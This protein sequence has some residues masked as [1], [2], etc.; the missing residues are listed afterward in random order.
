M[1]AQRPDLGPARS[2]C[3]PGFWDNDGRC[4]G[5]AGVGDVFLDGWQRAGDGTTSTFALQ[6]ADALVERAVRDG[7]RT[8]TGGSSSTAPPSRCCRPDRLDAGG[9]GDRG[10]PLPAGASAAAGPGAPAVERMDT[11]WAL[12]DGT[13]DPAHDSPARNDR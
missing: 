10:V 6:L 9:G 11:W 8:P 1:P 7:D 4:C 3:Y 5:T 13:H 12:P 2:G